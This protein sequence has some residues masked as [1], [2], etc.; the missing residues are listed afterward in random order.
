M[1]DKTVSKFLEERNCTYLYLLLA[2]EEYRRLHKVPSVVRNGFDEKITT[3]SLNH[4]A[5]KNI[6]DYM[7]PEEENADIIGRMAE[8]I[9]GP[10]KK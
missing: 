6:P 1:R 4:V 2:N 7:M 3:M 9:D 8:I 5:E 10:M